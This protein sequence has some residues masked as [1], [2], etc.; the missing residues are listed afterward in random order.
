MNRE[1]AFALMIKA[2]AEMITEIVKGQPIELKNRVWELWE[3]RIDR[4]DKF[5][6]IGDAKPDLRTHADAMTSSGESLVQHRRVGIPT[7]D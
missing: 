5:F 4:W 6:K 2:V 3:E 1:T 7:H